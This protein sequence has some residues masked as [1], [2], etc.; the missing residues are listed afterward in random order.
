MTASL[1]L[2]GCD[3]FEHL[4]ELRFESRKTEQSAVALKKQ[5]AA[6][7]T[8]DYGMIARELTSVAAIR[9]RMRKGKAVQ[10][11]T[12]TET[13]LAAI[14]Q[15]LLE[16]K[17]VVG[18]SN[19]FDLGGHSLKVVLLLMRVREEFDIGLGIEDV[20]ASDVTLERMARRIDE[21]VHFGGVGH[22]EYTRI[23]SAIEVMTEEEAE[24]ALG[25]ESER[26]ADPVS[27]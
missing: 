24:T 2:G 20:Y 1:R 9:R 4:A 5:A 23:L 19:F 13:R 26:N 17:E 12:R 7:H 8:V 14:W 11:E 10:L 22:A 16:V 3:V 6:E 15:D 18:E 27:R 25:E 21:L